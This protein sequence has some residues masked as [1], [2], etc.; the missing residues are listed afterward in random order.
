MTSY[1]IENEAENIQNG[2]IH[3]AQIAN[4]GMVYLENNLV[5]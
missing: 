2:N 4:F 5:C 1:L 3:V